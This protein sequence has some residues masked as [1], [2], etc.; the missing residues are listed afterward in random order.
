MSVY[1][2]SGLAFDEHSTFLV[3]ENHP[4]GVFACDE[5]RSHLGIKTLFGFK[6]VEL[7]LFTEDPRKE[8]GEKVAKKVS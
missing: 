6:Q 3:E 2:A 5:G 4:E 8:G 7:V 1:E